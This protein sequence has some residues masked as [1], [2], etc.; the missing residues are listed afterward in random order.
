M[1]NVA[2][3]W[4][5]LC[6]DNIVNDVC[7]WTRYTDLIWTS[8]LEFFLI[9]RYSNW[10]F[11]VSYIKYEYMFILFYQSLLNTKCRLL[12]LLPGNFLSQATTVILTILGNIWRQRYKIST[13][14]SQMNLITSVLHSWQNITC[15]VFKTVFILFIYVLGKILSVDCGSLVIRKQTKTMRYW[16]KA[17]KQTQQNKNSQLLHN[18]FKGID[19]K[20]DI[21]VFEKINIIEVVKEILSTWILTH[22][23]TRTH[24]TLYT[25]IKLLLLIKMIPN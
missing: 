23:L 4:V 24:K 15:L 22:F 1:S 25:S 3:I 5:E 2:V 12:F 7:C 14:K 17:N 20:Q 11:L 13:M 6:W 16:I 8:I 19:N 18:N 10:I 9:S 21:V